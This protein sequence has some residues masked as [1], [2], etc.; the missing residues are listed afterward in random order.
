MQA[1]G[2]GIGGLTLLALKRSD[3]LRVEMDVEVA[4]CDLAFHDGLSLSHSLTRCLSLS[5]TRSLLSVC[6][7]ARNA[8]TVRAAGVPFIERPAM[9]G[10]M[11]EE[12]D[13]AVM[14]RQSRLARALCV[15]GGGR[16]RGKLRQVGA[17]GQRVG[18]PGS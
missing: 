5:L 4:G 17:F 3:V 14:P 15:R 10:G 9:G 16:E 2:G 6:R 7:R 11:E 13:D 18:E 8:L 12:A 1:W